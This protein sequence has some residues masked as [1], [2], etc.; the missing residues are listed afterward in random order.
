[1]RKHGATIR[2]GTGPAAQSFQ[3]T[4]TRLT[5]DRVCRYA[6]LRKMEFIIWNTCL[7][8]NRCVQHVQPWRERN[9][10]NCSYIPFEIINYRNMAGLKAI[11][12]WG[13]VSSFLLV[14]LVIFRA[15]FG[16]YFA[17]LFNALTVDVERRQI[18]METRP[19]PNTKIAIDAV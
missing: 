9:N 6:T 1:M 8:S 7:P 14:V 4:A 12:F 3:S 2:G 17:F 19:G 13:G 5:A 10:S 16:G 11:F 15:L 18:V